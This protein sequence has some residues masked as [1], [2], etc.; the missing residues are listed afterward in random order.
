MLKQNP[1]I[2]YAI[3][4]HAQNVNIVMHK[5]HMAG[6]TFLPKKTEVCRPEAVILGHKCSFE[7]HHPE[8]KRVD[9]I[10]KWPVPENITELCQSLGLCRTVQIWI[11]DYSRIARP[12]SQL[13]QKEEN[14]EWTD[15]RQEAFETL[16]EKVTTAPALRPIDYESDKPV[17]I[18]VDTS[19]IAV[20]MVLSQIDENNKHCP[21]RYGSII[22]KNQE[23]CY[24]QP[25]LE[26]YGL[27]CALGST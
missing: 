16:K 14:F 2:C 7:G 22:L 25:K 8:D 5:V 9:K 12:L 20:G 4:E 18:S 21:A 19:Y 15:L 13:L 26:L 3:W 24:S 11:K 6:A 27:F 17:I 10:L 23:T 1:G